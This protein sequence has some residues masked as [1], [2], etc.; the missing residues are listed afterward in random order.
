MLLNAN[1]G[2]IRQGNMF[3]PIAILNMNLLNYREHI[4]VQMHVKAQ[5]EGIQES[6]TLK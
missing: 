1:L 5:Q 3:V 4:F 2:K 6:I